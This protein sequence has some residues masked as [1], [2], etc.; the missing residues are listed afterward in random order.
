MENRRVLKG[1]TRLIV[2]AAAQAQRAADY[3]MG[4]SA[5]TTAPADVTG[6]MVAA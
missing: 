1:D 2:H 3:I 4:A 5:P 6:D